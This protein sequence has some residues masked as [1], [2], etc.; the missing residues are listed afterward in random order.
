MVDVS[1]KPESERWA[2]AEGWLQVP[3]AALQALVDGSLKKG[4]AAAVARIAG[5]QA[6]KRTWEL[7][8]LCHPLQ[9]TG[10]EVEVHLHEPNQLQVVARVRCCQRTGVEMEALTAASIACLSLYDM[11]KSLDKGIVI[12]PIQLLSKSGGRSGTWQRRKETQ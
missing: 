3:P 9:L 5:I 8:P 6:A 11:L 2:E 12:G 10:V 1:A 4:D 7:I